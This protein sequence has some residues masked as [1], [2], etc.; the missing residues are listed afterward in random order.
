MDQIAVDLYFSLQH[1]QVGASELLEFDDLDSVALV[2]LFDFHALVD[3]AGV[4]LA[5]FVLGGVLVDAHFDLGVLEG[6]ELLQPLLLR[7]VPGQRLELVVGTLHLLTEVSH[8]LYTQNTALSDTTLQIGNLF[9][10][11]FI[12]RL[13]LLGG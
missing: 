4:S 10:F 2:Q 13:F 9:I 11:C 5:E 6:V 8:R 1:L 7:E 3:L 12:I